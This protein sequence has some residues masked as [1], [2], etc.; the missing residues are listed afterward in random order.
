MNTQIT[1][2]KNV[3]LFSWLGFF[4]VAALMV[5]PS[6]KED[7]GSG[8]EWDD[9]YVGSTCPYLKIAADE[10]DYQAFLDW[11]RNCT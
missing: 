4:L 10:G 8:E 5:F 6:L 7:Q 1:P 11:K 2:R 9:Q 3:Q